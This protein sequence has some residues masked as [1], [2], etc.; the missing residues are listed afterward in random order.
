MSNEIID[1]MLNS[2]MTLRPEE[3]DES[4]EYRLVHTTN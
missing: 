2:T 3:S 4:K 1:T